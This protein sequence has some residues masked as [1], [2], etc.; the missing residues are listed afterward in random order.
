VSQRDIIFGKIERSYLQY[1]K[2]IFGNYVVQKVIEKGTV[3]QRLKMFNKLRQHFYDL[4]KHNFGCR[5]MQK[6]LE[7]V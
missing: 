5:V 3:Q 1:A 2:D 6:I 7:V 4:S